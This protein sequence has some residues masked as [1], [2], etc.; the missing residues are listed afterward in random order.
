MP[1]GLVNVSNGKLLSIEK[2]ENWSTY[3]YVVES[4][5]NNYNLTLNIGNYVLQTDTFIGAL[6]KLPVTYA[7]LQQDTFRARPHLSSDFKKMMS[8]FEYW[9]GPYPF[10]KDGYK[11]VQT[12]Y[13]GMEH[14]SA[15]AY[16]NNFKKGYLGS[17]RSGTG[18]GLYWDYILIHE[19]AHEWFG[20]LVTAS[21]IADSWIQESF[22]TYAEALKVS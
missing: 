3:T 5:L 6:G 4:P 13:L 14:Q 2:K 8:C 16:G 19:S 22:T 9:M 20:N 21:D 7:F 12:S 15:I 17:D 10:Y 18:Q 1:N 11:L